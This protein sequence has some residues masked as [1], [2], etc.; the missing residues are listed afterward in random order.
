MCVSSHSPGPVEDD[1]TLVS[2]VTSPNYVSHQGHVEPTLFE[3]RISN[4]VSTDRKAH[5]TL[6]EF[7]LRAEALVADNEKKTNCGSIELIVGKIRSISHEGSR[8][9]AVYDT[10]LQKNR[11]HAEIV[12]TEIPAS[13]TPG[14]KKLRATLRKKVLDAC[15][16]DGKVVASSELFKNIR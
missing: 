1:E 15:M 11:S 12:C 6:Q 14:R 4:G 2:V 16:H 7:D 3:S 8:A 13:G 5:T 10:A 9:I